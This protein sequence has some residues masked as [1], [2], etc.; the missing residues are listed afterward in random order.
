MEQHERLVA[1][2]KTHARNRAPKARLTEWHSISLVRFADGTSRA[3][4]NRLDMATRKLITQQLCEPKDP[5]TE[6]PWHILG[7]TNAA[8]ELE[9]DHR[10]QQGLW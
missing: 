8:E 10:M 7:L 4:Y 5:V 2:S 3:Y 9:V 6:V 1:L